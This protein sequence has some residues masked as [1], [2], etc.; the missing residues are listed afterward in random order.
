MYPIVLEMH[1]LEKCC[2][3]VEEH[4]VIMDKD[5]LSSQSGEKITGNGLR[6]SNNP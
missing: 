4:E 2:S 1:G 6:K 3:D 5:V